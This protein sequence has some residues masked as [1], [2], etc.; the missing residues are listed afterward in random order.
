MEKAKKK[1][2]GQ[3]RHFLRRA[4]TRPHFMR[5]C[6][7][8]LSAPFPRS[9]PN[10]FSSHLFFFSFWSSFQLFGSS[11]SNWIASLSLDSASPWPPSLLLYRFFLCNLLGFFSLFFF[12]LE[13]GSLLVCFESFSPKTK[14][15][16]DRFRHLMLRGGRYRWLVRWKKKTR[17]IF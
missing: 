8:F 15:K 12:V 5:H 11:P 13:W 14:T 6:L 1:N 10:I 4:T 9:R 16:N 7:F 17:K 3:R 2:E